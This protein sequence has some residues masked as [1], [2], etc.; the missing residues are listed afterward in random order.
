MKLLLLLLFFTPTLLF[1]QNDTTICVFPDKDARFSGGHAEMFSYFYE[2]LEFPES[3]ASVYMASRF[4]VEFIVEKDGTLTG[5]ELV[6]P[7]D[8]EFEETV[9]KLIKGMPHWIPAEQDG[10]VV[11]SRCRVP[12]NIHLE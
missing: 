10:S 9:V 3:S 6:Y 4:Y 8:S 12:I 7:K 5:V 2:N 1:G 11:R